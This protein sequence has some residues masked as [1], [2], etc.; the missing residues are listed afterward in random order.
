M[1]LLFHFKMQELNLTG[2]STE[3][4]LSDDTTDGK[5]FWARMR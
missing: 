1:D 5:S 2:D 3:A 4:T